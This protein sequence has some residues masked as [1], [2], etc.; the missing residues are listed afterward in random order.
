MYYTICTKVVYVLCL[1]QSTGG[2]PARCRGVDT[3]KI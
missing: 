1:A 3:H 2:D